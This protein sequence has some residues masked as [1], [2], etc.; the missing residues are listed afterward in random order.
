[1]PYKAI[2]T[3]IW[4]PAKLNAFMKACDV[5]EQGKVL[6]NLDQITID[7][8]GDPTPDM[9][10]A[11]KVIDI[12][13]AMN[14]TKSEYIIS[15]ISLLC[16]ISDEHIYLNKGKVPPYWNREVRIISTG[17]QWFMLYKYLEQQGYEVA[18]D[19]HMYITAVS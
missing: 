16:V 4:A 12:I 8:N 1:M 14:D 15:L 13:K 6:G 5:F 19:E 18:K 10:E 11:G 3:I 2:Y 7:F 17:T 9:Q